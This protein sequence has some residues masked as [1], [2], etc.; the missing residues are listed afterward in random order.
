LDAER[1][2]RAKAEKQRL[3]DWAEE[4]DLIIESALKTDKGGFEHAVIWQ[5]LRAVVTP[6]KGHAAGKLE[7]LQ[8]VLDEPTRRILPAILR[9][10]PDALVHRN[11]FERPVLHLSFQAF[12]EICWQRLIVETILLHLLRDL[13]SLFLL[14]LGQRQDDAEVGIIISHIFGLTTA[15]ILRNPIDLDC[16]DNGQK[17]DQIYKK[18]TMPA[19]AKMPRPIIR[20]FSMCRLSLTGRESNGNPAR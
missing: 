14:F 8:Q 1:I 3:Y 9:M 20:E 19:K 7:L 5:R 6:F 17:T 12:G 2:H 10:N 13:H 18:M 4:N 11:G 16:T 15:A